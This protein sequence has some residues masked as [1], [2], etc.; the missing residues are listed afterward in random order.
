MIIE[1]M[2]GK[3]VNEKRISKYKFT[4]VDGNSTGGGSGNWFLSAFFDNGERICL[5]VFHS[6]TDG[7]REDECGVGWRE[8]KEALADNRAY[9]KFK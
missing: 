4:D 1:T 5:G 3:I 9:Y 6:S 7:T 2:N 8:L